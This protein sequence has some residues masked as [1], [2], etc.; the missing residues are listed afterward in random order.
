MRTIVFKAAAVAVTAALLAAGINVGTA[1]AAPSAPARLEIG[2][3]EVC[4][5][6]TFFDIVIFEY[7]CYTA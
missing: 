4:S 2:P 3:I 1:Q 7:D 6:V 5:V